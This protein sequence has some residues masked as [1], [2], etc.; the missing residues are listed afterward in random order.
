MNTN[1]VHGR[2]PEGMVERFAISSLFTMTTV[3][4]QES[5]QITVVG[6]SVWSSM[7]VVRVQC[8][9]PFLLGF[10]WRKEPFWNQEVKQTDILVGTW[11]SKVLEFVIRAQHRAPHLDNSH[12][13]GPFVTSLCLDATLF[14]FVLPPEA[15]EKGLLKVMQESGGELVLYR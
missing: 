12:Y 10:L 15:L 5:L 8:D 13:W 2:P 6:S 11:P 7:W 14:R 3:D 4:A 9:D 1:I